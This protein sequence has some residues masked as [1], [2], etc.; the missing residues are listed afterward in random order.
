MPLREQYLKWTDSKVQRIIIAKSEEKRG[1]PGVIGAIEA[2]HVQIRPPYEHRQPYV[3]RKS[4]HSIFFQA[5]CIHDT[6][7]SHCTSGW[8]GNVHD[9]GIL[10]NLSDGM[11][12]K[13]HI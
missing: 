9:S 10:K 1:F 8:P 13:L 4:C 3:N 2:T 11:T 7:F 6:S 12:V 5:V